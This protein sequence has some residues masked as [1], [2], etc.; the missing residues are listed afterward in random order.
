MDRDSDVREVR[1]RK[2]EDF[3]AGPK[4]RRQRCEDIWEVDQRQVKKGRKTG[5]KTQTGPSVA[6]KG[7]TREYKTRFN[8]FTSGGRGK[9]TTKEESNEIEKDELRTRKE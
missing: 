1:K 5:E 8:V 9:G 3:Q 6:V 7:G 2:R 4:G